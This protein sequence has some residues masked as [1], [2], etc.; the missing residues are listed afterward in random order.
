MDNKKKASYELGIVI[1]LALLFGIVL[2]NRLTIVYLF[3]F[4]IDEF[5][6]SY[7]EAGALA[8]VLAITWAFATW[9]FGGVSDRIGRKIILIPATIFFSIMSWVSGMTYSF[10]QMFLVRGLMGIGQGAT[11]PA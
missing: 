9:F 6:I 8:S 10:L 5:K 7:T 11:L 2:L 3:P 4:I 1:L